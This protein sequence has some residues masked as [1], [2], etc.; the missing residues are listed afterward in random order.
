MVRPITAL[1]SVITRLTS[2]RG[3]VGRGDF[4]AIFLLT[5]TVSVV[6]LVNPAPVS[7]SAA[8]Q[9]KRFFLAIFIIQVTSPFILAAYTCR[10]LH[11]LDKPS[12][13]AIPFL[14]ALLSLAGIWTQTGQSIIS[15]LAGTWALGPLSYVLIAVSA[16]VVAIFLYLL[17]SK[18][19]NRPNK[20]G[21]AP[22]DFDLPY[23]LFT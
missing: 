22:G 19:S 6:L 4:W 20:H 13:L 12:W 5:A 8:I 18:G 17:S 3:R 2:F 15:S 14:V 11:D 16:G 23:L 10:R 9:V 1:M 7:S 21:P